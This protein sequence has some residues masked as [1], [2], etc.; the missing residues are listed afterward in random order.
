MA[1]ATASE[2][3]TPAP[4]GAKALPRERLTLDQRR[5][6]TGY[7]F[8]SP[9]ILG[10]LIWFLIPAGIMFYLVFQ[11]WNLMSPPVFIGLEN[12]ASLFSDPFLFLSLKATVTYAAV[13]VP[14][15]LLVTFCLALLLNVP[16]PPLSIF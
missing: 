10:F 16:V 12:I 15:G 9:F 5:N 2:I 6:I 3:K 11:R 1:M 14:V 4:I 7:L 13:S 8:I